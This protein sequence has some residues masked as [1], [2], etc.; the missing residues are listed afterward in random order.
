[1]VERRYLL[2]RPARPS[3]LKRWFDQAAIPAAIDALA[4]VEWAADRVAKAA[5]LRP[6]TALALAL[7]GGIT[8]AAAIRRGRKAT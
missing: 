3:A 8:L 6:L 1:M 7:S 4:S 2:E 5:Q